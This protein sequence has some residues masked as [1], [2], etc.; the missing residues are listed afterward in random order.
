MPRPSGLMI[1]VVSGAAILAAFL[2]LLLL[3]IWGVY[4]MVVILGAVGLWEFLQLSSRMGYRAPPWVLF[5]LGAYFAFSGTLLKAV[6]IQAVLSLAL[7]VGLGAFVFAPG[8]RQ[9]LGRWAMGVAGAIYIGLPFNYYLLLF[10]SHRGFNW[11]LSVILAVVV[12]DVAALLVGMRFGRHPFLPAISPK[13]TVE[14]AVGG[15]VAAVLA[16]VLLGVG[17]LNV[18]P[19]HAVVLGVLVGLMAELGDLVESQM[20]RLAEVKDSSNLIPGHGGI[21]DRM[22]SVL[23]PPIL[24]F[25]YAFHFH[26]L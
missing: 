26:L 8:R 16:M 7:I 25:L 19:A 23:F 3:G 14:G 1:R 11:L 18:P 12:T 2:G 10:Q 24:V 6:D 17:L 9:G 13:K 4:A 5:P 22:D 15:F 21:L 20:K